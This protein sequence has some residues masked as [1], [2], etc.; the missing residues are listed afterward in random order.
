MICGLYVAHVASLRSVVTTCICAGGVQSLL[1]R[2]PA[3]HRKPLVVIRV[4]IEQL[5]TPFAGYCI[6][7]VNRVRLVAPIGGQP[8]A[9]C[10]LRAG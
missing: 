1:Q 7:A 2:C 9:M 4:G 5:C 8:K 10:S 6:N 3:V